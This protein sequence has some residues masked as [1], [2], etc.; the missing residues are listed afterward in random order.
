MNNSKVAP[1]KIGT[2]ITIT[3]ISGFYFNFE[4]DEAALKL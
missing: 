4:H 2:S 3:I 1:I